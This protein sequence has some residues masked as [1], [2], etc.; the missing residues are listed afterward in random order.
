MN[1]MDKEWTGWAAQLACIFEALAEKPGNVT[2]FKDCARLKFEQF[3]VSAAAV[4][5][6]F[7]GSHT[8]GVGETILRAVTDTH[9]L[10]RVNTNVGI[11]LLFAP[12][13]RAAST[14]HPDGLRAA[15][16]RVLRELTVQDARLAFKAILLAS[17][18]GLDEVEQGDIRTTPNEKIDMTLLE[19]MAMAAHRDSLASEYTTD[20]EIVFEIGLPCITGFLADGGRFSKAIVQTFLTILARVPDTDI[21]R[22]LDIAAARD[23]SQQ[24]AA[25]LELGGVSSEQGREAIALFD[26][27]LR[28]AQR[29]YNPGTS[30]DLTAAVILAFLLTESGPDQLPDLLERW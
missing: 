7:M 8:A 4:G 3:M 26:T 28:D 27:R 11:V 30:A 10:A 9:R 5:P 6:A 1:L 12:L 15:L 19:A 17:P 13:L 21:A 23:V 25:I 2:R 24:A 20:F 14:G 18:Q 22:K 16:A 29:H